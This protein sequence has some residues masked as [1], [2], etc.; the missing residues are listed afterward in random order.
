MTRTH[1]ALQLLNHGGLTFAD[2]RTITGWGSRECSRVL[3]HLC[4]Y[5]LVRRHGSTRTGV[6]TLFDRSQA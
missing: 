2:F 3:D 4:G 6:Y 1:A 5:E